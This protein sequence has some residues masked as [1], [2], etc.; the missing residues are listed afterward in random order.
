[1]RKQK[2]VVKEKKVV[3]YSV[4]FVGLT[5]FQDEGKRGMRILLPDGSDAKR[6]GVDPHYA[7]I[8]AAQD[9]VLSMSGWKGEEI[10]TEHSKIEFYFPQGKITLGGT[11][12]PGEIDAAK[13]MK[14][15]PKLKII[16]DK[17]DLD[18]AG[19]NAV[20]DMTIC[21]GGF[22]IYRMPGT[23]D[24]GTGALVSMLKV[25]H[26]GNFTVTVTPRDGSDNR[27][28]EFKAGSEIA[29][30]NTSRHTV[31]TA[32]YDRHF[33]IYGRLSL[34]PVKLKPYAT[35]RGTPLLPTKHPTF[36]APEPALTGPGCSNAS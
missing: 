1:M 20:A 5:F 17:F 14:A 22:G 29:F 2:K 16:D 24:D 15:L 3:D 4:M 13:Q 18:P 8:A 9:S 23:P 28:I 33:E 6:F 36:F 26:A 10:E 30:V 35:P 31:P 19:T 7:S 34:V 25:P 12:T 11:D 21:Q 32:N 27:T